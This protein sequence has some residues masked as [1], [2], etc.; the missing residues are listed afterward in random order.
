[1]F[2]ATTI[3]YDTRKRFISIGCIIINAIYQTY[4]ILNGNKFP[5]ITCSYDGSKVAYYSYNN[6]NIPQTPYYSTNFGND[7]NIGS[8]SVNGVINNNY[9]NNFVSN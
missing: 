2:Y 9:S 7:F 5:V 8:V 4:K 3:K 1:L 6:S